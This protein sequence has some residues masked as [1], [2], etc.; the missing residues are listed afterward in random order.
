MPRPCPKTNT[1]FVGKRLREIPWG[2]PHVLPVADVVS[3]HTVMIFNLINLF[4]YFVRLVIIY[5][6]RVHQHV[7]G[8]KWHEIKPGA[9]SV[10]CSECPHIRG[11]LILYGAYLWNVS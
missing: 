10:S 7:K 6:C 8:M 4:F 9:I 2:S 11:L 3:S 1:K 5:T